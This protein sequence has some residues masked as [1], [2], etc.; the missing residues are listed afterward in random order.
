MEATGFE[1]FS[2]PIA[3]KILPQITSNGGMRRG[4]IS[5]A[6]KQATEARG[7]ASWAG[8]WGHGQ[9]QE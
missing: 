9:E 4:I 1:E 2:L 8:H 6:I 7:G 5:R 3:I